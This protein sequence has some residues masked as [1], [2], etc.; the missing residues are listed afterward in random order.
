MSR[1]DISSLTE[2][3][4]FKKHVTIRDISKDY[5]VQNMYLDCVQYNLSGRVIAIPKYIV[6]LYQEETGGV[7]DNETVNSYSLIGRDS[8]DIK[9]SKMSDVELSRETLYSLL[10]EIERYYHAR[11]SYI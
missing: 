7:L 5:D 6:D 3:E 10:V 1:E 11:I 2:E 8:I 4:Y 9:D